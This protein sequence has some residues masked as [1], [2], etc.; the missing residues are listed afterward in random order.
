VVGGGGGGGAVVGGGGG[1]VVGGD[2]GGV[3]GGGVDGGR[4]VEGDDGV[5]GVDGV[6]VRPPPVDGPDDAAD[7]PCCD[8]R[9]SNAP[10]WPAR[11][12]CRPRRVGF[13]RVSLGVAAAVTPA[14]VGAPDVVDVD[15]GRDVVVVDESSSSR[16][17]LAAGNGPTARSPSSPPSLNTTATRPITA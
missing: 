5:D 9:D 12:D 17:S 1:V 4:V 7:G 6:D 15:P 8:E 13:A 2:V 11:P 16:V 14:A 10:D 3:V